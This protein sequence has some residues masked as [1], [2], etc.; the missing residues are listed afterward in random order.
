MI[1]DNIL[2]LGMVEKRENEESEK[3]GYIWKSPQYTERPPSRSSGRD[4]R[5]DGSAA[6][7]ILDLKGGAT[8]KRRNPK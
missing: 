1:A 5:K 8:S 7:N 3:S 6:P 2:L 4:L